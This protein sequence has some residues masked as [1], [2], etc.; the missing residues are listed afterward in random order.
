[1]QGVLKQAWWALLLGGIALVI[2][3]VLAFM[4][5]M[6]TLLVLALFFAASILVDGVFTVISAIRVRERADNWWL[7]LLLG[8]LGVVAGAIGLFAPDSRRSG[9]GAIA[10]GVCDRDRRLDDLDGRQ[11]AQGNHRRMAADSG[12]RAIDT[13]RCLHRMAACCR[14]ARIRMGYRCL[15]NCHWRAEDRARVPCAPLCAGAERHASGCVASASSG[16]T[17]WWRRAAAQARRADS[18][19]ATSSARCRASSV[20][21]RVSRP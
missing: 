7:W 10:G 13:F 14:A 11:A 19:F 20:N 18:S 17:C 8:I 21:A 12:R 1:M 4:Y 5:P 16:R 6:A 2:F 3:G 15:G 9:D